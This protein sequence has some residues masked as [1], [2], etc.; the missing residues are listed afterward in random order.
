MINKKTLIGL[1]LPLF[2]VFGCQTPSKKD[3]I[4]LNGFTQGTTYSITYFDSLYRDFST[5]INEIL[6]KIDS[7]MSLYRDSSVI[8]AFNQSEFGMEVDSLLA[9]VVY[10]SLSISNETHG[11]FDIT[12][13]PLVK[14][15]GFYA[16]EGGIPDEMTI[17]RLLSSMGSNMIELNGLYLSKK[18]PELSIDV[19]AIAQGFTVD[20]IAEFFRSMGVN[21]YLI[22]VGGEIRA[23]GNSPRNGSW[24]VGID[25]PED[26]AISG[27]N[28][29]VVIGLTN[30]SLVT[31]GNYRKFFVKDGI[32]YSHTIDPFTGYPVTHSLLSAT[33]VDSTAA[34][35][36]ALATAFMVM[37][38]KP[39]INW[40]SE[41]PNVHAYLVYSDELGEYQV[42]MTQG[43][44]EMIVSKPSN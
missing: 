3:Y 11:S 24:L 43:M 32:K 19:N 35:A 2:V 5:P 37:G 21:D 9:R 12:I 39:T 7:S 18:S 26:N 27:D 8:N 33:V 28:L 14:A 16:K 34:R 30:Q 10:L 42:W 23:S 13:A 41:H 25:K 4:K 6:E 1:V 29:Q 31:S 17:Q 22:E 38:L 15:W 36:D 20:V 44:K 40:L